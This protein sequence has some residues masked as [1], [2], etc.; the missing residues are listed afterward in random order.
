MSRKTKHKIVKVNGVKLAVENKK[1]A[2]PRKQM[3][4]PTQTFKDPRHP[5][6]NAD[7]KELQAILKE[8]L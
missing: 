5:D 7:K 2:T 8:E 3:A 6:R 1:W 4:P